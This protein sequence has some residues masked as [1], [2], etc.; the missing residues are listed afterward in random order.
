[1]DRKGQAKSRLFMP[2]YAGGV[3]KQSVSLK[4]HGKNTALRASLR[5]LCHSERR[6]KPEVELRSSARHSRAESQAAALFP[7]TRGGRQRA[8]SPTDKEYVYTV[9]ERLPLPQDKRAGTEVSLPLGHARVLTVPRTV[10]HC[11]RAASLP[12]PTDGETV[13]HCG[14]GDS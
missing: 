12:A 11:A 14:R 5:R 2:F 1:M 9:G 7:D 3:H 4:L 10:I 13:G 6:A 8:A